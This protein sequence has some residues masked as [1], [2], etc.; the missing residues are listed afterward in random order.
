MSARLTGAKHKPHKPHK[1][2][3]LQLSE[4]QVAE[5]EMTFLQMQGQLDT[6]FYIF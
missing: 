6:G 4:G 1:R 5:V 3:A 2:H